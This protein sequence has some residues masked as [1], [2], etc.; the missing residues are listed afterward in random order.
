M[1]AHATDPRPGSRPEIA[2]SGRLVSVIVAATGA[3][4]TCETWSPTLG[5]H[6]D[7]AEDP[8]RIP[9]F[10]S[11]KRPSDD[12]G[13]TKIS[14]LRDNSLTPSSTQDA[15]RAAEHRM[16]TDP[17]HLASTV[18]LIDL[19]AS[20]ADHTAPTTP[21]VSRRPRSSA[22]GRPRRPVPAQRR[23]WRMPWL[24]VLA[25]DSAE[26]ASDCRVD[27]ACERAASSFMSASVRF[28]A[29]VLSTST[30]C[31]VKSCRV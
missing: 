29:P 2:R 23:S 7:H 14:P 1:P 16:V 22:D 6:I 11:A 5:L 15:F 12:G 18:M 26:I 17:D 8:G 24:A 28:A 4:A 30:I 9:R 19:D 31:L 20:D 27:S 3:T 21:S 25:S 13:R 10:A